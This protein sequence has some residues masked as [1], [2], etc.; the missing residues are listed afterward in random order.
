MATDKKMFA[1]II[2]RTWVFL[3]SGKYFAEGECMGGEFAIANLLYLL[4]TNT[5]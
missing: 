1:K 5:S 4:S 3:Y 2:P